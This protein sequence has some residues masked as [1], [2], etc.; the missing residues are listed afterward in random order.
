MQQQVT[1][2]THILKKVPLT[3]EISVQNPIIVK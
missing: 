1:K 2:T 3:Q